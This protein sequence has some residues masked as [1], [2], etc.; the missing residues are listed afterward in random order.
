MIFVLSRELFP[1]AGLFF[2]FHCEQANLCVPNRGASD[3]A[4]TAPAFSFTRTCC[5]LHSLFFVS[6]FSHAHCVSLAHSSWPSLS[7]LPLLVPVIKQNK[8][9][10]SMFNT[11]KRFKLGAFI[12]ID[13][14][15]KRE[16]EKA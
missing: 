14:N 4:L 13:P 3:L 9:N 11:F 15:E 5:I 8:F 10:G 6:T 1:S 2:H 12:R 7:P 16:K